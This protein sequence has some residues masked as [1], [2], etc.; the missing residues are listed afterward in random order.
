MTLG[1]LAAGIRDLQTRVA[2]LEAAA[3][4]GRSRVGTG[5]LA[6]VD[7]ILAQLGP[8]EVS[9]GAQGTVV[10]AG[11]GPG[12]DGLNAW[13]V[14]RPW[15]DLAEVDPGLVAAPLAGLASPHRI[16]ILQVLLRGPATTA[17]ITDRLEGPSSGQL[18]HHL[19]E[20]LAAGL[21]YQP[22][23]GTYAVRHQ[24]VVPLL[25]VL[26][27]AIDLSGPAERGAL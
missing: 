16:Q 21:L 14:A 5:E 10:Y 25:T 7:S 15:S 24:H 4:Q 26:S 1:E 27:C 8:T 11:A 18:F 22:N 20:L 2:A 23:R 13:Q 3:D 19:K 6:A 12:P 9:P 17:E